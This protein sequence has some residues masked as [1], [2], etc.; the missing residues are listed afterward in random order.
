MPADK[1]R[2]DTTVC[3]SMAQWE[4]LPTDLRVVRG[5]EE[6]RLNHGGSGADMSLHDV[7]NL[8]MPLGGGA[9]A[10]LRV[11]IHTRLPLTDPDL[12]SDIA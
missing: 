3:L 9:G 1:A 5:P 2:D 4:A 6:E 10:R 12:H 8:S 7:D 11:W